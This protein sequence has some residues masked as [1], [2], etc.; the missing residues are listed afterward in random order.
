MFQSILSNLAMLLLGHLL[1][2]TLVNHK[3]RFTKKQINRWT[4][5]LFSSVIISMF[6]L[7]IRYDSL[8]FDLRLI[9]LLYLGLFRGWR[10]AL[11]VLIIA[12]TWRYFMGGSG[13]IPGILFGMILPILAVYIINRFHKNKIKI[14]YWIL[15]LTLCW[16]ISDI[17]LLFVL[18]N[19]LEV[20]QEIYIVRYPAFIGVGLVYYLF[21][22]ESKNSAYLKTQLEFLAWHDS[23]TKL[24]NKGQ[25]IQMV[26]KRMMKNGQVHSIAMIDID[27]FKI[28]N[29]TYGHLV[30]DQVLIEFASLLKKYESE[31]LIVGRYGGEEFI[32][33]QLT[34]SLEEAIEIL[35]ELGESTRRMLIEI[36]D[37]TFVSIT[38]SMGIAELNGDLVQAIQLADQNLYSAKTTGKDRLMSKYDFVQK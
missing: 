8:I 11:S 9:P 5:I 25:F 2:V 34:D 30:G 13:A 12:S 15:L 3:E 16:S 17:P 20:F 7:P 36:A 31:Q 24:L 19:G 22:W 28:F 29:D 32:I 27:N 6:Y 21:I 23:L 10:V 37:K 14:Y 18:P 1:M 26:E 4:V 38:V 35:D 33:Y